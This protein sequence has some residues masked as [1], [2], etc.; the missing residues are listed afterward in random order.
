MSFLKQKTSRRVIEQFE[1]LRTIDDIVF[2]GIQNKFDTDNV[3]ITWTNT[4]QWYKMIK[5]KLIDENRRMKFPSIA[6]SRI[7]QDINWERPNQPD[8][9]N[10]YVIQKKL[11]QAPRRKNN[12]TTYQPAVW[13]ITQCD[14]PI[15]MNLK[16]NLS[17]VTNMQIDYNELVQD[18]LSIFEGGRTYLIKQQDIA[19]RTRKLFNRYGVHL[20]ISGQKSDVLN[21]LET[22]NRLFQK[23]FQLTSQTYLYR[24]IQTYTTKTKNFITIKQG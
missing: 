9:G 18:I 4:E 21:N 22:G 15:F 23:D 1:A 3:N 19:N 8:T 16:Y 13:Q 2:N 5:Q 17:L 24:N 12:G 6:I 14:T 20:I 7:G 10:K 11:I